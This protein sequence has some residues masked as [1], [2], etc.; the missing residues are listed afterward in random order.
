MTNQQKT[1]LFWLGMALGVVVILFFLVTI[2]QKRDTAPTTN[3]VSFTGEGKVLAKPDVAK[4]NFTILTQAITS[5]AAQDAN[6]TKSNEVARFL[7]DQGIADKDI[8][9]SGYQI[10]PQ[11]SIYSDTKPRIT[12]YQASQNFQV[13]IR[14]LENANEVL[15]GVVAAGVN[16]VDQLQFVI[17][18]PEQLKTQARA[19]AIKDAK[20]KANTLESQIGINLGK[21]VNFQENVAG[22]PGPIM[23]ETAMLKSGT[24]GAELPSLPSGEN[25]LTVSVTITYQIK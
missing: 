7:K 21:I 6:S 3:Q 4:L 11:Q 22:Y 20:E 8:K 14:N 17:D 1:I 2:Q 13:V 23:Y 16:Q 5:K 9:T 25:E 24:G 18:N 15:D 12:A 19:K 10:Y